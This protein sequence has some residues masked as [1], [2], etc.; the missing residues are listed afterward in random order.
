M[1]HPS[2]FPSELTWPSECGEG[3]DHW[4]YEGVAGRMGQQ[5]G[6]PLTYYFANI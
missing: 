4:G 1:S 3:G 5:L 2:H 6:L